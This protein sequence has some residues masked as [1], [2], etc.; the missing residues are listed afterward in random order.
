MRELASA[1]S[2]DRDEIALAAHA[3]E[4]NPLALPAMLGNEATILLQ[5]MFRDPRVL[6]PEERG[7]LISRLQSAVELAP[8]VVEIRVMLGMALCV[9]LQAQQAME[10]LRE[11]VKMEPDN[12]IARLKFG[13][14]LMRLRVCDQ[15]AEHTQQAARL[16][17]NPIQSELARRQAAT[18]RTMMR[19][20]IERGGYAPLFPRIFRSRR[21]SAPSS[22]TPV[23]VGSE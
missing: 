18:I 17:S 22:T 21:K 20:G 6:E 12:F 11:A 19:E 8:Q 14:L 5:K 23:L 1:L 10:E 16:A 4:K 7:E 3:Q 13:E 2:S 9:D 15:A